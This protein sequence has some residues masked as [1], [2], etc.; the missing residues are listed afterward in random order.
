M[1]IPVKEIGPLTLVQVRRVRHSA[2]GTPQTWA[3]Q[4]AAEPLTPGKPHPDHL[5]ADPGTLELPVGLL[6][7]LRF[8]PGYGFPWHFPGR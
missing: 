5:L 2:N 8:L 7:T 1:E 3:P 6:P 4:R